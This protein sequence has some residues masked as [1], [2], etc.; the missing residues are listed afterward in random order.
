MEGG[1]SGIQGEIHI[2]DKAQHLSGAGLLCQPLLREPAQPLLCGTALAALLARAFSLGRK[3]LLPVLSAGQ[4]AGR[5]GSFFML[6]DLP[7]WWQRRDL[8]LQFKAQLSSH[9]LKIYFCKGQGW[10]REAYRGSRFVR[11]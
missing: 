5:K 11:E 2:R 7:G 8:L 6:G 3:L 1:V 10:A 4:Q 9:L